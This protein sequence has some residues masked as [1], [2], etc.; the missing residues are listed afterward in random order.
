[1][2]GGGPHGPYTVTGRLEVDE[3][4][5]ALS[6]SYGNQSIGGEEVIKSKVCVMLKHKTTFDMIKLTYENLYR[7]I[8]DNK[9]EIDGDSIEVGNEVV[10]PFE[11][12]FGG[13]IDIYIPIK[14]FEK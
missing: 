4:A 2:E 9:F 6:T 5:A 14:K 7:F 11:N 1:M 8:K 13:I 10:V 3:W 12:G